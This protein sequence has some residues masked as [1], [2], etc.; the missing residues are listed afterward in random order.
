MFPYADRVDWKEDQINV[1]LNIWKKPSIRRQIDE[2]TTRYKKVYKTIATRITSITASPITEAKVKLKIKDMKRQYRLTSGEKMMNRWGY[3]DDMCEI[4]TREYTEKET[5]EEME[6]QVEEEAEEEEEDQ[7]EVEE[8][9]D[10]D[11]CKESVISSRMQQGKPSD[12]KQNKTRKKE[13]KFVRGKKGI[14]NNVKFL[15]M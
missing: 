15:Y 4:M 14:F 11:H 3:Y 12:I 10:G 8:E 7:D 1:L 9:G 2:P 13:C 5:E 6:D